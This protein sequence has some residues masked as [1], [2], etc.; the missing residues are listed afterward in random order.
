[1]I[2]LL[3]GREPFP[4]ERS[5]FKSGGRRCAPSVGSTP[6]SSA[7]TTARTGWRPRHLGE[8]GRFRTALPL[9][10]KGHSRGEF[11]FDFAR[12][13]ACPVRS[14]VPTEAPLDRPV[15]LGEPQWQ[16]RR[17]EDVGTRR[18]GPAAPREPATLCVFDG[19][20]FTRTCRST[21]CPAVGLD[22][23]LVQSAVRLLPS[24]GLLVLTSF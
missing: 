1:M 9:Y 4:V 5:D 10:R 18:V 14:R 15:R 13:N 8:S 19:G 11:V 2:I 16:R 3:I 24:R 20:P 6:T 17:S 22:P 7:D 21:F 23:V 12:A